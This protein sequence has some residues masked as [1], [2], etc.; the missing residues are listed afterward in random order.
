MDNIFE[1]ASREKLRFSHKGLITSEDLWDLKL[2][3]LDTIAKAVNRDLKDTSEESFLENEKKNPAS[4]GL[5]V[6]LDILKHIIG[7]KQVENKAKLDKKK[8][9]DE[10]EL[11]E[12]LL[13][14][15]ET[16]G[17]KSLSPEEIK[18]KI[19]ELKG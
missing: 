14:E 11:L 15:K 4:A 3:D 9:A 6:K 8:K 10:L 12:S 5:T 16:E 1:V 19:T 13:I 18:A 2:V 17:L 7:V